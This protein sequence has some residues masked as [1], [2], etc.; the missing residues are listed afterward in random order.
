MHEL[1]TIIIMLM[2]IIYLTKKI[3]MRI[4][5]SIIEWEESFL[6][7]RSILYL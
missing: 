4:M 6:W 2:L 1:L 5:N 7:V 3:P